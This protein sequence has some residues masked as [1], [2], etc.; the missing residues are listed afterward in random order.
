MPSEIEGYILLFVVDVKMV[1]STLDKAS[2]QA[3]LNKLNDLLWFET[4][5]KLP[6]PRKEKYFRCCF[7]R[8]KSS[9]LW[10]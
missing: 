9:N 7:N 3:D 10:Y 1:C 8:Q 5:G 4:I 6:N 2:V